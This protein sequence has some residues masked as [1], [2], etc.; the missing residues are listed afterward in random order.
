MVFT[1]A[2]ERLA[3]TVA[4]GG[5]REA[6]II[7]MN[8]G[9]RDVLRYVLH[10]CTLIYEPNTELFD[11]AYQTGTLNDLV[12]F[13]FNQWKLVEKHSKI[14]Y[15]DRSE[16]LRG[17]KDWNCLKKKPWVDTDEQCGYSFSEKD[18]YEPRRRTEH[19]IG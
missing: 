11:R 4:P 8:E 1:S 2:I 12:L 19:L 7:Q 13:Y 3:K 14:E 15:Q 9:E 6:L 5:Y 17:F 18:F 10:E 16:L